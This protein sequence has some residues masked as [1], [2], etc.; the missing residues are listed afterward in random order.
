[1]QVC[2]HLPLCIPSVHADYRVILA[3]LCEF[4]ERQIKAKASAKTRIKTKKTISLIRRI[5]VYAEHKTLSGSSLPHVHRTGEPAQIQASQC[6]RF[7]YFCG[8]GRHWRQIV[9]GNHVKRH[10]N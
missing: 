2:I 7:K 10:R 1:M 5:D 4:S 9:T 8:N 6:R 3:A